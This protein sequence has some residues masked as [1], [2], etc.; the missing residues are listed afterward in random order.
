MARIF[1]AFNLV[2]EEVRRR[3]GIKDGLSKWKTMRQRLI[4]NG[5]SI[6]SANELISGIPKNVIVGAETADEHWRKIKAVFYDV[7][8]EL[9]IPFESGYW[10]TEEP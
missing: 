10:Y 6:L 7:A 8:G 4:D 5:F 9:E 2:I 3:K 1:Q